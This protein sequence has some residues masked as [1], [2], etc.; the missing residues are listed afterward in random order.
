MLCVQAKHS[1]FTI[2]FNLT[3]V[4]FPNIILKFANSCNQYN[5]L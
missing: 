5:H 4:P 2:M 1:G 3:N